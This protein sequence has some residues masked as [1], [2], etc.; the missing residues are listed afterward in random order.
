MNKWFFLCID[1]VKCTVVD[2]VLLNN[3]NVN[4]LR[5]NIKNTHEVGNSKQH[6]IIP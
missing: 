2:A 3:T 5:E 1:S 4:E 6:Q